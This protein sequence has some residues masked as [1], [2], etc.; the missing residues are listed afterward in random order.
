[1]IGAFELEADRPLGV[2]LLDDDR[3]RL[4]PMITR[5]DCIATV[6]IRRNRSA[7]SFSSGSTSRSG[8]AD[9]RDRS[10]SARNCGS[11]FAGR[12]PL[13]RSARS[14][15]S[16]IVPLLHVRA[17]PAFRSSSRRPDADRRQRR[18][19]A[20]I[21]AYHGKLV[22]GCRCHELISPLRRRSSR[23]PACGLARRLEDALIWNLIISPC[24]CGLLGATGVRGRADDF[25]RL[26]EIA[27]ALES[28][29]EVGN[30][31]ERCC[32]RRS[33]PRCRRRLFQLREPQHRRQRA[34]DLSSMCTGPVCSCGAARSVS[35]RCC[36][37]AFRCSKLC[38]CV[39]HAVSRAVSFCA[40]RDVVVSRADSCRATSS[41]SR[42]RA[43][44]RPGS[45]CR[46][47]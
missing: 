5:L 18:R 44:R 7:P 46:R 2:Q 1:M 11:F 4:E 33:A 24:G 19:T 26:L 15:F 8:R 14:V 16:C 6:C 17:G 36:S 39:M 27:R 3:R 12:R 20:P 34:A 43:R 22:E 31:G 25:D 40:L 9:V 38:T 10:T 32:G 29:H 28:G 45:R 42:R 35:T 37:C 13:S 30:A 21:C 47:S 41:A 23:R